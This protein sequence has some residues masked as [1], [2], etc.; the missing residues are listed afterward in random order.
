MDERQDALFGEVEEPTER[1]RVSLEALERWLASDAPPAW[2]DGYLFLRAK[3]VRYRD[4]MLATWLSLGKDDRGEVHSREDFAHVMGVSR[5]TTYAWEGR[6]PQIRR[7]A[8]LLQVMRLRGSRLAEVDE[9]TFLAAK[10]GTAADR[11][12]YYQRAGV[13]EEDLGL[14]FKDQGDKLEDMVG[15]GFDRALMRAYGAGGEEEEEV[16]E[17]AGGGE[18]GG[19]EAAF[20]EGSPD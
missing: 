8:E 15:A 3:G 7:W 14:V 1:E 10:G 19:E 18:D 11:K 2:L 13:W 12:L 5:A 9:A 6:R 20:E 4:A 16:G 17:V